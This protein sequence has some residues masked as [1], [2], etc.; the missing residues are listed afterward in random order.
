M[1]FDLQG[2]DAPHPPAHHL[3]WLRPTRALAER[4]AA[5]TAEPLAR[6]RLAL[7]AELRLAV[8]FAG[9]LAAPL[10][11]ETRPQEPWTLRVAA[12]PFD[13]L[14]DASMRRLPDPVDPAEIASNVAL[15]TVQSAD[16]PRLDALPPGDAH[17]LAL[18]V[19][20]AALD[21][22][23]AVVA[24]APQ[25]RYPLGRPPGAL[26]A[27]SPSRASKAWIYDVLAHLP[28]LTGCDHSAALL[29]PDHLEAQADA[30]AHYVVA[31]ERIFTRPGVTAHRA[32]HLVGL[33]IPC[34]G[35]HGGLLEAALEEHRRDPAPFHLFLAAGDDAGRWRLL[36]GDEDDAP[37]VP[38]FAVEAEREPESM[39]L[40]IPLAIPG[41]LPG[42]LS[43]G[44]SRPMPITAATAALFERVAE[45]FGDALTHCE[46][47][48]LP[49][50]R[51]EVLDALLGAVSV[52]P[53][54][55][56]RRELVRHL[57]PLLHAA[58]GAASV[59][60]GLVEQDARGEERLVFEN[61]QG[62]DLDQPC[63]IQH[64]TADSLAA[65]SMR[66]KRSLVL[67]G[68]HPV[69]PGAPALRWNN[70]IWVNERLQRLVDHRMADAL[71]LALRPE[72]GWRPLADYYKPTTSLPVY[73]GLAVPLLL[74]GRAIGVLAMDFDRTT[75][76]VSYSGFASERL[77]QSVARLITSHLALL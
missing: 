27:E 16:A 8:G 68:G 1:R 38:R 19:H 28:G 30:Q 39:L 66:L 65:L 54:P 23:A 36:G 6:L 76:W 32:E 35:G 58:L 62:W 42:F 17:L 64:H 47:F 31:A 50:G 13:A 41:A 34:Y 69:S 70:A 72:D 12:R 45:R 59:A 49:S 25:A 5:A 4:V 67:A 60:I 18:A 26:D 43:L 48:R 46:L 51:L 57:T 7:G 24:D 77:Y 21:H 15:G 61:P 44:Y 37:L 3:G 55:R 53:A 52:E 11:L 9:S 22:L 20:T 29:L 10:V 2:F 56:T 74:R 75:T 14:V 33:L 40:L 63:E 73:V 71:R